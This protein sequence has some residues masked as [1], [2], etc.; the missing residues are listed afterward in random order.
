MKAS[1]Q[2]WLVLNHDIPV[3]AAIARFSFSQEKGIGFELVEAQGRLVRAKFIE[4]IEAIEEVAS[5]DGS[6][7]QVSVI[8]YV[9]FDFSVAKLSSEVSLV[10][11]IKP[12]ASL[13]SFVKM[14]MEALDYRATLKKLSFDLCSV[15][16]SIA[17]DVAVD[18]VIVSKLTVSQVPLG[19]NATSR[20][21]VAST[22]N[23]LSEFFE[24]YN[25]PAMKIEKISI[26]LRIRHE[27]EVLELTSAGSIF[28]T[29]GVEFYLEKTISI[30]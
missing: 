27:P 8:R 2:Q 21:E 11:I 24:N 4:K 22:E 10:K 1:R 16:A 14:L 30:S 20:V 15:Y 23:A 26:S 18:R 7:E 6:V 13:K 3:S 9:T 12:P 28:C 19:R 17:R 5:L 29:P 25:A